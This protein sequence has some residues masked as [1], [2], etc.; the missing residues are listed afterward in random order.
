[1][2]T[3]GEVLASHPEELRRLLIRTCISNASTARH[4]EPV[5]P[6]GVALEAA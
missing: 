4:A 6:S 3:T 5:L 2:T 1:M